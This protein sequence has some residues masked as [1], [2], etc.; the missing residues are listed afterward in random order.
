MKGCIGSPWIDQVDDTL[1]QKTQGLPNH[2][3]TSIAPSGVAL[4]I[5]RG[6]ANIAGMA[7]LLLLLLLAVPTIG[8]TQTVDP[9]LTRVGWQPMLF[10]GKDPNSFALAPDQSIEVTSQDSVS[11]L[12]RAVAVDIDTTPVLTWRWRV[13]EAVPATDLSKRGED[14]RSLAVYVTFPFQPKEAS[15][16]E[17]MGR[18]VVEAVVG[19]EAPGRV[20][21]YVWG[22]AHEAGAMVE[23]PYYGSAGK[24]VILRPAGSPNG[25]WFEERID[26]AADYRAVFGS[27]PPNPTHVAIGA[28]SDDSK[29]MARGWIEGVRFV[30]P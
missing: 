29:S 9:E 5:P 2:N 6:R 28:D 25:R 27:D 13:D 18:G 12:Q 23:S 30:E 15:W 7:R 1:A 26:L 22:G 24:L 16:L 10:D 11:L 4:G 19:S 17:R 20:L 3:A 21:A 14:D 8:L